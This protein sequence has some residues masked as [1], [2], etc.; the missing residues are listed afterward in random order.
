MATS[1][2]SGSDSLTGTSGS[3]KLVGGAGSDTIDGAAG[4]DFINAGGGDDWII[5]DEADYKII[6]GGGIDTLWF[7]GS[8]QNL[9]F[10][11]QAINGIEALWLLGGGGHTVTFSA[12]DV[13]R[14]SD[15]DR[16]VI[17]GD[18][19][20]KLFIGSG[21]TFSGLS[22]DGASQTLTNGMASIVV[23]LPV[24]IDGFS[25]NASIAF[26]DGADN[27]VTED[28]NS[29]SPPAPMLTATGQLTVDDQNAGQGLLLPSLLETVLSGSGKLSS[30][31]L[32]Q[33]S[34]G[35][36]KLSLVTA[37]SST[38]PGVYSYTYSVNNTDVQFLG[39]GKQWID[40]F[41]VQAIDGK[42][43]TLNFT[44]DGVNDAPTG[45]VTISGTATEDQTL[46][47][48]TSTIADADGLG[49][50]SY[51]W[52]RAS[53]G[54][55][56]AI[57]G[58]TAGTYT[59]GD[60]DVGQFVRVK[61]SYTDGQGTNESLT[62]AATNAVANVNDAP[63]IKSV[64]VT[65]SSI[66]FTADDVD[67][68]T[69]SAYIGTTLLS[70]LTVNIGSPTTYSVAPQGQVLS[71]E[72]SV[73]DNYSPPAKKNAGLYV[74]IGTAGDNTFTNLTSANP[75]AVY[76][77]GGKDT[78][79]VFGGS[80][81]IYGGEGDDTIFIG[82]L[83]ANEGYGEEGNDLMQF[84]T[85]SNAK[86]WGGIGSDVFQCSPSSNFASGGAY[87]MDFDASK[88][89]ANGGDQISLKNTSTDIKLELATGGNGYYLYQAGKFLFTLVGTGL[90]PTKIDTYIANENIVFHN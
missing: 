79:A 80:N 7:K 34:W 60:N 33:G 68:P 8:N 49:A 66:S 75:R 67:S 9:N 54:T 64:A 20:S 52:E 59:L 53:N 87:V 56:S 2:V 61:V 74:A 58:A 42:T 18:Q 38:A 65:S 77:E 11:T 22:A 29:G 57:S 13:I 73:Q 76:G 46:S 83:G 39:A 19:T 23:Q 90:D 21:W 37:D 51:Q 36:L 32:V 35:T 1:G 81:F 45:A 63:T 84:T 6:G 48:I 55:W 26:A 27:S 15:T 86:L 24:F 10:G 40:S 47:A 89:Y 4:S 62:S 43:Q 85:A 5:Y 41:T 44:I 14:V 25:N 88:S 71:G 17:T 12:A 69:L 72:L 50:F 30:G 31:T 82:D 3:D 78:I 28:E 70:G 16:F